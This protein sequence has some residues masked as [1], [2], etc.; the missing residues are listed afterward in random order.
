M[1]NDNTEYQKRAILIRM[2]L[3][4]HGAVLAK[5]K[6][7]PEVTLVLMAIRLGEMEDRPMDLKSLV[8]VTHYPRTSVSRHVREL[9]KLGRVSVV[10]E[11]RRTVMRLNPQVEGSHVKPFYGQVERAVLRASRDL[12]KMD[13]L[14]FDRGVSKS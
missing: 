4:I 14:A 12:T 9:M 10:R 11:G 3:D 2:I 6:E 1:V 7:P 13:P 5:L 8:A